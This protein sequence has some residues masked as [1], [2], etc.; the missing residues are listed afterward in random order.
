[1]VVR[2]GVGLF[3]AADGTPVVFGHEGVSRVVC[4][5]ATT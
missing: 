4:A 3:I 1:L 2:S 5:S